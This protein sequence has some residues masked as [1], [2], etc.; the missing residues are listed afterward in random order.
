ML[1]NTDDFPELYTHTAK[2]ISKLAITNT[3]THRTETHMQY[4]THAYLY[5]YLATD[6][7]DRRK[8][9]PE[10]RQSRVTAVIAEDCTSSLNSID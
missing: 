8:S 5:I 2:Y 4:H 1:S 3:H 9:L 6:D 7:D 10:S